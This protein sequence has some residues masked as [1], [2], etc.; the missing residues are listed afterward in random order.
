ME[1]A[2]IPDA[3]V[4]TAGATPT[5]SSTGPT[6]G[7]PASTTSDSSA[8]AITGWLTTKRRI[9]YGNDLGVVSLRSA[10]MFP[11]ADYAAR[12]DRARKLMSASGVDVVLL[13]VGADL[14]YFS[15]YEDTP[16]ERLTILVVPRDGAATMVVP[17]LE[18]PR[19]VLRGDAFVVRAW[20]ETED[21]IEIAA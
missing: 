11:D 8:A 10:P 9:R 19:V 14:P 15:G 21:P 20:D 12:L 18:A 3:T 2:P 16:L 4:P 6:A 5:T 1:A 7:P 13:S 17:R